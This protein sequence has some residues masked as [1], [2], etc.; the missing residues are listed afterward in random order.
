MGNFVSNAASTAIGVGLGSSIPGFLLGSATTYLE[1]S[2]VITHLGR[3]FRDAGT[4]VAF[5]GQRLGYTVAETASYVEA[6]GEQTNTVDKRQIRRVLGFARQ[7]GLDPGTAIGVFGKLERMTGAPMSEAT[8]G[9]MIGRATMAG[10][11]QGRF[12]EYV[13]STA[14]LGEQQFQATGRTDLASTLALQSVPG[15]VFGA[16]D[17]RGQGSTGASFL[18]RL[19]GVVSGENAAMKTYMM[20][21]MGFGKAGGPGYIEMRKRLEAGIYGEEGADN[22]RSLFGSMRSAGM[23]E[24]AMFRAVE[25]VSGG[26]LKA[27][28]IEALVKSLGAPDGLSRLETNAGDEGFQTFRS[29]LSGQER[30]AFG[31]EG[32]AGLGTLPGR[33]SM[34]EGA[35]VQLE[36]LKLAVGAPMAQGI[37]DIREVVINIAKSLGN[38]AGQDLG[39]MLTEFTGAVRDLSVTMRRATETGGAAMDARNSLVGTAGDIW[40]DAMAGGANVM[41][42]PGS[43]AYAPL[44]VPYHFGVGALQNSAGRYFTEAG[45]R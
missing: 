29:S 41:R 25:S 1:L 39:A 14:Q 6:L 2:K 20:R 40:D 8:L 7:Q 44:T 31:Q 21:V 9:E 43:P 28:E 23:G 15:L 22:L 3:R 26:S 10:M 13:Q 16:D 4:E 32:F 18:G 35:N 30:A 27:H 33:I 5:F 17:P 38:L 36:G 11:G 19:S 42:H 24:G 45:N 34:G 37:L 12:G